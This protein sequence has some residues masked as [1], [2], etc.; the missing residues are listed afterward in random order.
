[1]DAVAELLTRHKL[2][3]YAYHRMGEAGIL[4]E[5]DRIELI[6]GELIEMAPIGQDHMA[7]ANRLNE[8]LVLAV[9]G[10][11]IVSVANPVR[12]DRLNELQPDFS[13]LRRRM[14]FYGTGE[15]PHAPDVLLVIEVAKSSL[16]FD[17]KVKLPIYARAGIA[18]Y[19]IVDVQ[20]RL[21]EVYRSPVGDGYADVS[22]KRPGESVALTLMPEVEFAIGPMF[23]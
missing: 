16:R 14:D 22:T 9:A 19:W 13:I 2:D 1:M 23:D 18:E 4:T 15:F 7:I 10:R 12:I 6:N 20:H 17:R 21:L 3:V 11:A 8:F 5:D